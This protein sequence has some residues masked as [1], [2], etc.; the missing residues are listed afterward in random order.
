MNEVIDWQMSSSGC[1]SFSMITHRP[2]KK[3]VEPTLVLYFI[4]HFT[5][6]KYFIV[7]LVQ[8]IAISC[9]Q[10][11]VAIHLFEVCLIILFKNMSF[12][13]FHDPFSKVFQFR[14]KKKKKIACI[15]HNLHVFCC[16]LHVYF[17]KVMSQI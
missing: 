12:R 13:Q 10:N 5:Y 1:R 2:S 7:H 16:F 9:S 8:E 17:Y 11:T 3:L 6:L 14:Y 4:V 15:M